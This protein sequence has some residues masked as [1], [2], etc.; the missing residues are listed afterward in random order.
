[1]P[2]KI[3]SRGCELWCFQGRGVSGSIDTLFTLAEILDTAGSGS[4]LEPILKHVLEPV[5]KSIREEWVEWAGSV[6]NQ[7][8]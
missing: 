1:M 6:P 4:I 7:V 8:Q 5:L 3:W 2:D